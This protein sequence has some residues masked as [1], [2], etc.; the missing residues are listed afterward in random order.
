[1][2]EKEEEEEEEEEDSGGWWLERRSGREW[3]GD[4]MGWVMGMFWYSRL[5]MEGFLSGR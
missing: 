2:E 1:M 5:L 3:F 4:G